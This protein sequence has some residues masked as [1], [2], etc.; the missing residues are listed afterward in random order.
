[1]YRWVPG[2]RVKGY[3]AFLGAVV[4]AVGWEL[5]Q[6][7]FSWY[8][9]SGLARYQLIYGSLGA[10]IAFMLWLYVTAV[11]VLYGA[12]LSAA[13]AFQYRLAEDTITPKK[14]SEEKKEPVT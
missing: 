10:V 8:L 7:G 2:T 6:G 11:V 3:E 5:A 9:T 1:V 13:V 4:A 14:V 12:H